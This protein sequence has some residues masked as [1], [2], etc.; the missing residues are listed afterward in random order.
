MKLET[1]NMKHGNRSMKHMEAMK[2]DKKM[3]ETWAGATPEKPK[4]STQLS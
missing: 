4:T 3:S 2:H 1:W